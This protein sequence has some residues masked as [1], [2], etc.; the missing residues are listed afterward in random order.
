MTFINVSDLTPS[1]IADIEDNE[2]RSIE[3]G[4]VFLTIDPNLSEA[5][6]ELNALKG[7]FLTQEA[8]DK[9]S[10]QPFDR[11][12]EL[13][14]YYDVIS[15]EEVPNLNSQISRRARRGLF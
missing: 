1:F 7:L 4:K 6:P 10:S 2:M 12:A 5:M 13:F 8:L 14:E 11:V 15:A 9:I 3:G